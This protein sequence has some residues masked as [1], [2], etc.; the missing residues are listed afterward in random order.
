MLVLNELVSSKIQSSSSAD[1]AADIDFWM[2]GF[3]W[4]L[5][6][7]KIQNAN[8]AAGAAYFW[9]WGGI[10]LVFVSTKIQNKKKAAGAAEF[11]ILSV[12]VKQTLVASK[13]K[14]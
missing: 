9:I 2:V 7:S 11:S 3:K 4:V 14:S 5:V 13:I 1:G 6:A 12:C 8:S 10:K